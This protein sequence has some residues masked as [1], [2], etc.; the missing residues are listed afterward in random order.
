MPSALLCDRGEESF[1]FRHKTTGIAAWLT[2]TRIY[3]NGVRQFELVGA[4]GVTR[5][6]K[7]A[8]EVYERLL[9][10]AGYAREA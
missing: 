1:R 3:I 2:S 8:R 10:E 4:T 6:I 9:R 7:A 5:P